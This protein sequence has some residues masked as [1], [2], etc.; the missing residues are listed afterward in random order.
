MAVRNIML[1]TDFSDC[2]TAALRIAEEYAKAFQAFVHVVHVFPLEISYPPFYFGDASPMYTLARSEAQRA[3]LR[4]KAKSEMQRWL[5]A[6]RDHMPHELVVLEGVAGEELSQYAK[7]AQCDLIIAGTHG[8]GFFKRALLGSVA[9]FLMLHAP[10]P[11]L[12]VKPQA[13]EAKLQ[14]KGV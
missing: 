8:Y 1:A 6:T 13:L 5:G 2:S 9:E 7:R 3:T 11:V 4:D 12:T 10:C 14:A